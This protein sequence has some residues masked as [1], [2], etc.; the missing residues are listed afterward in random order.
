M[1]DFLPRHL[2][3]ELKQALSSAK[4]VNIV[5]ARDNSRSRPPE[6]KK[7]QNAGRRERPC[8]SEADLTSAFNVLIDAPRVCH[9][10]RRG[11]GNGVSPSCER[12]VVLIGQ[13]V[14]ARF[15]SKGV[16]GISR[17]FGY[18]STICT[19]VDFREGACHASQSSPLGISLNAIGFVDSPVASGPKGKASQ[20][21]L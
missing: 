17:F 11:R 8:R 21:H 14:I 13:K 5:G 3:T 2:E 15:S 4:V 19:L 20:H 6:E 12:E 7:L 10:Y 16:Q 9:A 1:D 18:D